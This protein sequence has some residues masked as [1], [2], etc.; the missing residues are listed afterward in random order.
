ML[1]FLLRCPWNMNT[2]L[3]YALVWQEHGCGGRRDNT[4]CVHD[5][6]I[7]ELYI[8]RTSHLK[9]SQIDIAHRNSFLYILHSAITPTTFIAPWACSVVA[10]VVEPPTP[11]HHHHNHHHYHHHHDHR[12]FH[13]HRYHRHHH[14][15]HYQHHYHHHHH[16]HRRRRRLQHHQQYHGH[17]HNHHH[18]HHPHLHKNYCIIKLRKLFNDIMHRWMFVKARSISLLKWNAFLHLFI[19][20]SKLL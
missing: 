9:S 10:V 11:H 18:Q 16:H 12:H 6:P 8:S 19:A 2:Y 5:S 15:H 17:H 7:N 14:H 1:L 20:V 13:L 3:H 4:E